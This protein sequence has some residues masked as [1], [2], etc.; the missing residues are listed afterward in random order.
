MRFFKAKGRERAGA[1]SGNDCQLDSES[2]C[3][4]VIGFAAASDATAPPLPKH[5][6]SS[7]YLPRLK[8]NLFK[9][10]P[11]SFHNLCH[12]ESIGHRSL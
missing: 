12:R 8:L 2:M 3:V 1:R 7:A 11:P 10:F 5:T 9:G 6:Q 4:W